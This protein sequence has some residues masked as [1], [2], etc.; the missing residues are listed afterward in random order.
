MNINHTPTPWTCRDNGQTFMIEGALESHP[1]G[2]GRGFIA[3]TGF[4]RAKLGK[5][6]SERQSANAEYIVRA[7]NAHDALLSALR[8][9]SVTC[10]TLVSNG[11]TLP[12]SIVDC[13]QSAKAAI[14]KAAGN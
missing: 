6:P 10:D 7:C 3:T 5:A 14:A 1:A 4:H 13:Y 9:F 2:E 11:V 12:L 8:Q